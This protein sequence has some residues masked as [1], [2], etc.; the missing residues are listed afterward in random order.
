MVSAEDTELQRRIEALE[1]DLASERQ[2]K[3]GLFAV[4]VGMAAL[5]ASRFLAPLIHPALA[6]FGSVFCMV[7]VLY[8]LYVFAT[9]E[10]FVRR[11][12]G[13]PPNAPPGA[14]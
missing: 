1:A 7:Y 4:L 2:R 8:G 5:E 14:D 9:Q 11:D 12:S 3:R 10:R 6:L 13:R